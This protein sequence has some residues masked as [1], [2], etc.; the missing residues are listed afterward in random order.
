[1]GAGGGGRDRARAPCASSRRWWPSPRRAATCTAPRSAPRCAPRCCPTRR[2]SSGS[3]ARAPATR[4]TCWRACTARAR[5]RILLLGHLDTVVAHA[6][7]RPLTREGEKLVGSGSVD[8]KGGV[9]LSLGA[10]RLLARRPEDYAEVALLVVCDEEW[11]KGPLRARRPLRRAGTR[12]CA[13]RAASARPDGDDGVVV[14]RKAAGTIKV[15]AHGRSR[16]RAPRPTAAATRCSRSAWPRARSPPARPRRPGAPD[17]GPDRAALGR[18][19]QRR[20]RPRRALLRPARRRDRRD[21]G[22]ARRDPGEHE[23]VRLEAELIRRWPGMHSEEAM[24]RAARA[25]V[26]RARAPDRPARA[27]AARATPATSRRPSR[28]PSTG[29]ARAAAPRTTRTS[30]CSRPRWRAA[31]R[32]RWR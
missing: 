8:M 23:G 10:M 9:V 15:T 17:R 24:A 18:R 11:R 7:H 25:G 12:A 28:S 31:P 3:R 22:G 27:A 5:K 4:P 2:R 19:V 29:S 1:M 20:A 6:E 13:S 14:R 16:T 30:S 26:G 21:R 32:S